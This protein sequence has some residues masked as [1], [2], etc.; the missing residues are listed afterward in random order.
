MTIV[1]RGGR[2]GIEIRPFGEHPDLVLKKV[3]D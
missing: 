3:L 1:E 2:L